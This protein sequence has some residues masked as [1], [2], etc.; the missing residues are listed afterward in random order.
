MTIDGALIEAS[1][2]ALHK[3]YV[4]YRPVFASSRLACGMSHYCTESSHQPA[5]RSNE[6]GGR[7]K[8]KRNGIQFSIRATTKHHLHNSFTFL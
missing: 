8:K 5:T 2:R 6:A 7:F 3:M 1:G 4:T